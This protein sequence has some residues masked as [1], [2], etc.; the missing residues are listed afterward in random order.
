MPVLTC[1][2]YLGVP[3]KAFKKKKKYCPGFHVNIAFFNRN[4]N[5]VKLLFFMFF[6]SLSPSIFFLNNF[7][8]IMDDQVSLN[9]FNTS[10]LLLYL[11]QPCLF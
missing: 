7:L 2:K 4:N 9:Q 5:N 6:L 10:Q 8:S 11:L 1:L 3:V